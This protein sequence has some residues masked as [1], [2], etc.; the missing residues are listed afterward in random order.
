MR[1]CLRGRFMF[2]RADALLVPA[3]DTATPGLLVT[4]TLGALAGV[5]D[6]NVVHEKSG[7]RMFGPVSLDAAR[8]MAGAYGGLPVD[9]SVEDLEELRNQITVLPLLY[10]NWLKGN[11]RKVRG[12]RG[13]R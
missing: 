10:Q 7:L 11:L 5:T 3:E 9:W 1:G 6:W 8:L 2:K 13:T 4:T 12:P